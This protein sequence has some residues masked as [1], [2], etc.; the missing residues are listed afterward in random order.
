MQVSKLWYQRMDEEKNEQGLHRTLQMPV[1]EVLVPIDLSTKCNLIET[2][3]DNTTLLRHSE[4]NTKDDSEVHV[5]QL[6]LV[7]EDCTAFVTVDVRV[8][9]GGHG[10][11]DGVL[12]ER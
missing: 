7:A 10:H 11:C 5:D 6:V 1:Q 8:R 2:P 9:A 4:Q 3:D 12:R